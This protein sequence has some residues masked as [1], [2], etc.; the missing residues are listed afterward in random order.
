MFKMELK[1]EII[2]LDVRNSWESNKR[3]FRNSILIPFNNLK[4]SLERNIK[5]KSTPIVIFCTTRREKLGS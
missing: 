2:F 5:N 3:K 4:S 1:E